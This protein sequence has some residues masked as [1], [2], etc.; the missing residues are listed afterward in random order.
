MMKDSI[1][2]FGSGPVAAKALSLLFNDFTIEAIITKPKPAHHKVEFPV[3]EL[4]KKLN[5]KVFTPENK[6]ELSELFTT[7]PVVSRLG[8]VIDY[9]I[10]INQDVIDYLPLGIV[11]S[12][13]SLLPQ[14]RGADPIT[15]SILSGQKETGVSLMLI[16]EKMDEGPLLVQ[17]R[18]PLSSTITSPQL[19]EQLIA[20]S[21]Q[22][23]VETLPKYVSG[24]L[25]PYPQ[26]FSIKP[27]YSHKLTKTDGLIDWHKPAEQLE[28]E[29]RAYQQWPKSFSVLADID[30]IITKVSVL[31]TLGQPGTIIPD[32]KRL[33]VYCGHDALLVEKL[34][35]AGKK[36]MSGT[37][38]L[39]GYGNRL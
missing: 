22:L 24:K 18:H 5:I 12:H 29:I 3:L 6:Q 19:T 38:F 4:A 14:W 8:V 1:V 28:R 33:V 2:F 11:N 15:F 13:F 10:I 37:A 36:E 39:A 26:D 20:L 17:K 7:K 31:S 34:K 16:V 9:G 30:V 21:H 25:E 35:P 27:S 23:L 32:K